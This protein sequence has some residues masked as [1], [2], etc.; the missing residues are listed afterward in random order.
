MKHRHQRP[1]REPPDMDDLVLLPC[2]LC[3]G[4]RE[5]DRKC[6]TCHGTGDYLSDVRLR[7]KGA[8]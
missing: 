8:A 2:P 7:R 4:R 5:P 1:K 6:P 3:K